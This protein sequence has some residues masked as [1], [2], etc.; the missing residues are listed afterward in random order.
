MTIIVGEASVEHARS[1]RCLIISYSTGS[2][3]DLRL[4]T[5]H[6]GSLRSLTLPVLHLIKGYPMVQF[7]SSTQS[8]QPV[9][10]LALLLIAAFGAACS[11]AKNGATTGSSPSA[12]GPGT[13]AGTFEGEITAKIFT[14]DQPANLR[15][16]I[17][18]NRMRFETQLSQGIAQTSVTLM[19]SS[20]STMTMLIPQTKTYM[21][22]NLGQ[23]AGEMMAQGDE[24]DSSEDFLKV[25]STGKTETIAGFTCQY[26]LFG[27]KQDT[28]VCLANGLGY[29]A[30]AGGGSGGILEK[31]K[32][33]A[34]RDKIKAQ[35]DANPEFAKFVESG[36]FPL[37]IA[38]IENGQ[39]RTIMEVTKVERKSIDDSLFTVP[40]DYKKMEIPGMP[41]TPAGKK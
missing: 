10:F 33:L 40:A 26:W 14:D 4:A 31:L 25:S 39:S 30:S 3:S 5:T 35:L 38:E 12:S 15:Y 1:L 22:M 6:S 41:G 7:K 11:G 2:V 18:G 24:K 23:M 27:A 21:T 28:E 20:A 37:K 29:F 34:L 17:K 19:D 32:N 8:P 16:A 9:I 36:A 13:T